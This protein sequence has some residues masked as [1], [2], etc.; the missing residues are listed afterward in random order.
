MDTIHRISSL[1][2]FVPTHLASIGWM[3]R[4]CV[5][6]RLLHKAAVL[7]L[8]AIL[9]TG[10]VG[11][12]PDTVC[13][14]D[15]QVMANITTE[16]VLT[17]TAGNITTQVAWDSVSVWGIGNDSLRYDNSYAVETLALPLRI[18]TTVSAFVILWHGAYD[19]LYICHDN[20]RHF[21]SSAC[22]CAVYHTIDTTWV[23]GTFVDS[24]YIVN[25]TVETVQQTNIHLRLR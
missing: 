21:I 11:C 23:A 10:M 15:I 9:L 25:S 3:L 13:R 7:L 1:L 6:W 22:G 5:A 19:T 4:R 2:H 8:G 16:W 24:L 14:Q 17:D 18:D 12:R 20:T